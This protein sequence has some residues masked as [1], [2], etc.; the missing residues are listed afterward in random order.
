MR[1]SGIVFEKND[2]TSLKFCRRWWLP[3]LSLALSASAP[4]HP[5]EIV[6]GMSAAFSGPAGSLGIEL[7][8]GSVAYFDEINRHGGVHERRV[9]LRAYDDGYE[10]GR[11]IQN[12]LR[13]VEEDD[14]FALFDYVG[15]PTV[16]RV[17]PLLRHYSNKHLLMLF[18][19]TGAEPQRR[20]PY[21]E[22]V[23]NLR[24]SYGDET[25]ALV[26][27]FL[28]IGRERVGV[29]FQAD[30]YGRGGWEGVR[31]SLRRAGHEVL[32]EATYRRGAGFDTDFSAQVGILRDAGADAVIAV[33]A[34]AACAGFIRDARDAGWQVPIAN[35]SFSGSEAMAGL[36]QQ[37]GE[38]SGR[39]YGRNLVTSQVVPS[40]QNTDL[41]AVRAY[42]D[43]MDR[44]GARLPDGVDAADYVPKAYSF[45][46][47][48]GYLNARLV[49]LA[50]QALGPDPRR[51][52]LRQAIEGLRDVD[53]GIGMPIVFGSDR[54]QGMNAVFLTTLSNGRF[55]QIAGENAP[56]AESP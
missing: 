44:L 31:L 10:P 4:A 6:L 7:Y 2:I 39:V 28:T 1:L 34:Y 47:F 8:R 38:A 5:D 53:L 55:I 12:T 40:Y 33:C 32:S 29:F 54:H 16:T 14:V 18:P 11:A 17:L 36:L 22:L 20:A 30:A 24:A 50:L 45:A 48:E 46:S 15:T 19:F 27:H 9:V 56:G 43:L 23:F 25:A 35:L 3:V 49:V 52:H 42:R 51:E 13:L 41:P 37:A 26:G 21:D